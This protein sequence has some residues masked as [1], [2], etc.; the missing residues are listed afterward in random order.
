MWYSVHSLHQLPGRS[1]LVKNRNPQPGQR[2]VV[3]Y[4]VRSGVDVVAC[5][6]V[7]VAKVVGPCDVQGHQNA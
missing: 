1:V 6:L 7:Q 5:E 4:M 2:T 3:K